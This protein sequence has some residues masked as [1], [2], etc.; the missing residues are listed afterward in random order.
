VGTYGV[1]VHMNRKSELVRKH[2]TLGKYRAAVDMVE[3]VHASLGRKICAY[4]DSEIEKELSRGPGIK[5]SVTQGKG[6]A[7]SHIGL[8]SE[9]DGKFVLNFGEL[10][11]QAGKRES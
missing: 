8:S 7:E 2:R 9:N 6:N 3:A 1:W 4:S 11:G 10:Y 5:Y